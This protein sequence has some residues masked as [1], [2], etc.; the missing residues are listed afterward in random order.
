[1]LCSCY[2]YIFIHYIY[3]SFVSTLRAPLKSLFLATDF[4]ILIINVSSLFVFFLNWH[5]LVYII[6]VV[7]NISSLFTLFIS[8][9]LCISFFSLLPNDLTVRRYNCSLTKIIIGSSH[10][11]QRPLPQDAPLILHRSDSRCLHS[12]PITISFTKESWPVFSFGLWDMLHV[13]FLLSSGSLACLPAY[14]LDSL[15]CQL[16]AWGVHWDKTKGT[17]NDTHRPQLTTVYSHS[18][19]PVAEEG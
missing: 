12:R 8:I 5:Y 10:C 6:F 14:S 4:L 2:E 17:S 3:A 11:G 15:A 19:V 1:M 7:I 9:I 18:P 13:Y 16:F